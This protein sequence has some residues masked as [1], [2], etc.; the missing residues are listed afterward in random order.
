[1]RL[2]TMKIASLTLIY[3]FA[4]SVVA[5]VLA[6]ISSY[7]QD[8]N[9][10]LVNI[11]ISPSVLIFGNDSD[12]I[13]TVHI[14][15]PY[16]EVYVDDLENYPIELCSDYENDCATIDWWKADDCGNFVAKFSMSDI[17]KLELTC[18]S[19]NTFTLE[20]YSIPVDTLNE[21]YIPFSG[22]DVIY[23][24]CFEVDPVMNKKQIRNRYIPE[25]VD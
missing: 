13:L 8:E 24:K 5:F 11:V 16:S 20:G 9:T 18:D 23:V 25:E 19:I 4:V 7:G 10:R 1:M 12:H 22:A 3:L 14:D 15:I 21:E 17:K 6:P 2:P